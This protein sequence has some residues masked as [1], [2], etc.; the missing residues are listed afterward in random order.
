MNVVLASILGF[1]VFALVLGLIVLIHEG[2]HFLVAKK[3][4]ILCHEYSIGM[5]PLLA[6]K[7]I[8]ETS[9]SLRAIPLGGYVAMAGEEVEDDLLKNVK[10]VK[11]I[12]ND[13]GYVEK[14]ILNINNPLYLTEEEYNALPD[15]EKQRLPRKFSFRKEALPTFELVGYDLRGTSDALED[16]LYLD[17]FDEES[18]NDTKRL[19]VE[20]NAIV[21]FQKREEIQIAPFDRV[22]CNK[23]IGKRFLSVFAGPLMNFVLAVVIFF[24]MGLIWG[25]A[26]T[27]TTKVAN[28]TGVAETAGLKDSDHIYSINGTVLT[29]WNSLQVEMNKVAKGEGITKEG[30]IKIQYYHDGDESNIINVD[31]IYPTIYILSANFLCHYDTTLNGVVIDN[32]LTGTKLEEAGLKMGDKIVSINGITINGI[33]EILKFFTVT[34]GDDFKVKFVVNRDGNEITSNETE[35]YS[36]DI[37]NNQGYPQTKVMLGIS[38]GTKRDFLKNLYMPFVQTGQ[39]TYQVI[40]TLRLLFKKNSGV[41]ITDLS[42]PVGIY[43]LF[44]Q[45]VQGDEAF[46]NILYW[47]GLLSVNIGLINLFP[48]PALDGGRLAFIIYEAITKKKPTPKVENTIHNI[49]FFLLLGL[50]AFVFVSDI[51]KCLGVLL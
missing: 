23:P 12:L 15:N 51:I 13:R 31:E 4:G 16:E 14:I 2:G 5:G 40:D 48:L 28:V 39:S 20:R 1:I 32:D 3:S 17:V 41:K 45:L 30:A 42:G 38:S 47:M 6:Q 36:K 22:F 37:L 43:N 44:T 25:Y 10:K 8:G 21:N 26:D 9:Y 49:G 34:L 24:I 19:I 27:S 50:F 29:D 35:I 7:K 18:D 33:D 46:Y 11:V